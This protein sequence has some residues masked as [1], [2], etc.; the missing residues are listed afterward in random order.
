MLGKWWSNIL[1]AICHIYW[2]RNL[3]CYCPLTWFHSISFH[4][5]N[6]LATQPSSFS[7]V[8]AQ[9]KPRF[10]YKRMFKT[11]CLWIIKARKQGELIHDPCESFHK[12][13]T[14]SPGRLLCLGGISLNPPGH[15]CA[16]FNFPCCLRTM[17]LQI[18]VNS[19]SSKCFEYI[20]IPF[21]NDS[22][23]N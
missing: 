9:S 5:E 10:V 23:F 14:A 18:T 3:Q 12:P 16:H 17:L 1:Y 7:V 11:M 4:L 22:N 2:V 8:C 20:F 13:A 21:L 6:C 19:M 15:A